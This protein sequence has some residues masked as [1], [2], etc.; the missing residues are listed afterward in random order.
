MLLLHCSSGSNPITTGLKVLVLDREGL[1]EVNSPLPEVPDLRVST[2]TPASVQL[3]RDVGAWEDIEP[4][5]AP[6]QSMQVDYG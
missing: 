6:F 2:V 4:R 3:F 1:A 5:S